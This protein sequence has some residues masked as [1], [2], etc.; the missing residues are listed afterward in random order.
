MRGLICLSEKYITYIASVFQMFMDHFEKNNYSFLK[1]PIKIDGK[2]KT[3][4][5]LSIGSTNKRARVLKEV[6]TS[7]SLV[8]S[9]LKKLVISEMRKEELVPKWLKID[10]V[11]QVEEISFDELEKK[12]A[13]TRKN[14][15][16]NGI[17]FDDNFNLAFLEQELNSNV[18]IR[19]IKKSPLQL[20][21]KNINSYMQQN[22]VNRL[23]FLRE[24]YINRNVYLFKTKSL[25]KNMHEDTI[26]E[27]YSNG[28][29]NGVRKVTQTKKEVG[30]LIHTTTDYLINQMKK[31]GQLDNGYYSPFAKEFATDSFLYQLFA[32]YTLGERYNQTYGEKTVEVIECGIASLLQDAI[33]YKNNEIAFVVDQSKENEITLAANALSILLMV[34]YMEITQTRK[35]MQ[36]VQLLANGMIDLKNEDGEFTHVITYPQFAVKEQRRSINHDG[37]ATFALLKL[38]EIDFEEYLFNEVK[39]SFAVFIEKE[40]WR[41]HNQWISRAVNELVIYKPEDQ[42]FEFGLKNCNKILSLIYHRDTTYPVFLELLICTYKMVK[43][44]RELKKHHLLIHIDEQLLYKTIDHR[45]EYQRCGFLYPEIA[46]Y[47]KIPELVLNRFFTRHQNFRTSIEEISLYLSSYHQYYQYR[48]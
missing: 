23:P 5:F 8:C 4:V 37:V 46:M 41:Y 7:F 12:I 42:Y 18:M 30:K 44:I 22:K 21:E 33:V 25:F 26:Y 17:A 31:T 6:G 19:S 40:Y 13:D 32:L 16:R 29:M 1:Q 38:Y 45:A 27:L 43:R 48:L 28:Q 39:L 15:F 35:Y 34:K 10:V 24:M 36:S 2:Q 47:M 14:Y 9:R 20:D 3:I 11:D